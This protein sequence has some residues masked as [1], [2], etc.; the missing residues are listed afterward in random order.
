MRPGWRRE[1]CAV[2]VARAPAGPSDASPLSELRVQLAREP[3]SDSILVYT[4]QI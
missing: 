4:K 3:D 1:T 2:S